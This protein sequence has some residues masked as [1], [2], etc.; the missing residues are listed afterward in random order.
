MIDKETL[1]SLLINPKI[2]GNHFIA[3][4][5][6]PS[7]NKSEKFYINF[8]TLLGDC[9]RC[10]SVYN[11]ITFLKEIS[12]MDLLEG[13]QVNRKTIDVGIVKEPIEET[14]EEIPDVK[15][16]IGFKP[17]DYT[18][19]TEQAVKYLLGRKFSKKDF[20]LYNPGTTKL[21]S[22]YKDYIII[23]VENNFAIKGY[24]GRYIGNDPNKIRYQNSK[25]TK[26]GQLIFGLD[27][28]LSKT[29]TLILT[30]GIFDK[31]SVTDALQ[32]HDDSEM[33]CVATFGKKLSPFQL[34]LLQRTSIENVIMLYD[35]RDAVNDIKKTGYKL[36]K[37]FKVF[38]GYTDMKDP[39][40]STI[41]EIE[42][43]INNAE[44]LESF[45]RSKVQIPKLK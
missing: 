37:Y 42:K 30:E 25:K 1:R 35:A 38:A 21:I 16:P 15:L 39:G 28:V 3:T 14:K 20:E 23:P 41:S 32:L 43:M 10:G 36:N 6:N 18:N 29:K 12:R 40:E 33:K 4:C 22:K 17:C 31:V 5:P 26:F 19:L 27:E 9:K 11:E 2:S 24:V 7:C 8:K 13:R 34:F 45:H 44:S